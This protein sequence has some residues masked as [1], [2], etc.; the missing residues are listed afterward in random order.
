M[1]SL[2]KVGMAVI[3]SIVV[4]CLCSVLFLHFSV[5]SETTAYNKAS[6]EISF[7][8]SAQAM[9]MLLLNLMT[10]VSWEQ[11]QGFLEKCHINTEK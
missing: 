9:P 6:S 10:N 2:V 1:G 8:V 3:V 4:V 11:D 7:D 5:L